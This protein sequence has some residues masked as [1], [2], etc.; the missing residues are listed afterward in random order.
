[1]EFVT[2]Q[3]K[4]ESFKNIYRLADGSENAKRQYIESVNNLRRE[5]GLTKLT[6]SEEVHLIEKAPP[7]PKTKGQ[8]SDMPPHPSKKG[9][10]SYSNDSSPSDILSPHD[11]S[12]II[13]E[14]VEEIEKETETVSM[15]EE[16][17]RQYTQD[18]DL[19]RFASEVKIA[20]EKF[21]QEEPTLVQRDSY[22]ENASKPSVYGSPDEGS[23]TPYSQGVITGERVFDNDDDSLMASEPSEHIDLTQ[24]EVEAIKLITMALCDM[25]EVAIPPVKSTLKVVLKG[26]FYTCKLA[27]NDKFAR[28]I[29]IIL[30]LTARHKNNRFSDRVSNGRYCKINR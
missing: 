11:F 22:I 5:R 17:S 27:Y 13:E 15:S 20:Y 26:V 14:V 2:N 6:E 12:E 16:S 23:G 21:S 24:K 30:I 3:D 18:L 19:R 8:D 28:M 7:V 9:R 4:M 29:I 1:M 10:L 25:G